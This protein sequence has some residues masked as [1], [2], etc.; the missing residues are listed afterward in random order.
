[1]ANF[2][3]LRARLKIFLN[4][5]VNASRRVAFWS[6]LL[7]NDQELCGNSGPSNKSFRKKVKSCCP[8][9]PSTR[10]PGER[11]ARSAGPAVGVGE[12][13]QRQDEGDKSKEGEESTGRDRQTDEWTP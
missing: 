7:S 3:G 12:W 6:G 8:I 11:L 10:L 13:E 1:M 2:Y 9:L 4:S 5:F